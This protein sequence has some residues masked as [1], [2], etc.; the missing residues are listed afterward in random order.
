MSDG[1]TVQYDKLSRLSEDDLKGY[2]TITVLF[3]QEDPTSVM[4]MLAVNQDGSFSRVERY[5]SLKEF[6]TVT[7]KELLTLYA[8]RSIIDSDS[9]YYSKDDPKLH[10][11]LSK[12]SY[13]GVESVC[14]SLTEFSSQFKAGK[15]TLKLP[16]TGAKPSRPTSRRPQMSKG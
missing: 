1:L 9:E 11:F 10:S 6:S 4:A 13:P 15:V 12:L 16:R 7:M 2:K 8:K 5:E 14:K 3:N